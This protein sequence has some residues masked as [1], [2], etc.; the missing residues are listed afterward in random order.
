MCTGYWMNAQPLPDA[1]KT[2]AVL[3]AL[4]L[5][6]MLCAV[7]AWRALRKTFPA[8]HIA[9]V[10]LPW[11]RA[12][13]NRFHHYFDEFIEFP[14]FPGLPERNVEPS[15]IAAFLQTMQARKFDLALQMQGSGRYANE[16]VALW[17]PR[18]SAGFFGPDDYVPCPGLFLP[19]PEGIPEIH[20]HMRLMEFLGMK[21]NN[22]D[23]LEFPLDPADAADFSALMSALHVPAPPAM[24]RMICVHPG[25]NSSARRWSATGFAQ[26]ADTLAAKGWNILLTGTA[27]ERSLTQSVARAM[28]YPALDL[29]GKTTLGTLGVLFKKIRLLISNSTGVTHLAC[30]FDLPS[31]VIFRNC[32]PQRWG[33]LDRT[34]HRL[35]R[36]DRVT[37]GAIVADADELLSLAGLR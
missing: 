10:G 18:L 4:H 8:A 31:I 25:G 34:R 29:S 27:E 6:D 26:V 9:L 30:A 17:D 37:V 35:H 3:R 28:K 11:A 2:I 32:N 33:A 19:Y 20:R 14:G 23:H 22:S 15:R 16:C 24:E 13:A 5:G 7:P 1:I 21:G 36:D 12:F